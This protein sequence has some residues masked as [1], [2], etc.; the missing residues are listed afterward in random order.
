MAAAARQVSEQ[1]LVLVLLTLVAAAWAQYLVVECL[2]VVREAVSGRLLVFVLLTLVVAAVVQYLVV[3]CLVVWEA[4]PRELPS[5]I[6]TGAQWPLCRSIRGFSQ[7]SVVSMDSPAV[8]TEK[9]FKAC[10]NI[11]RQ[12]GP[13]VAHP[14]PCRSYALYWKMEGRSQAGMHAGFS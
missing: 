5:P 2:L 12:A 8:R 9:R 6:C 4:V 7:F 10:M 11:T 14:R 13:S 1:L 3:G